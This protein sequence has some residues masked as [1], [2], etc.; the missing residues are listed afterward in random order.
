MTSLVK[1]FL[2]EI[3]L[4]DTYSVMDKGLLRGSGIFRKIII[5]F[6][7]SAFI[8][9][10][11]SLINNNFKTI[12]SLFSVSLNGQTFFAHTFDRM[13]ALF[14]L[15]LGILEKREMDLFKKTVK[16]GW[17]VLDIGANIGYPSLLFSK[18]VGENGKV[19]AFEPDKNNLEMLRKNIK[20]NNCKNIVVVPMAVSDRTGGG[21]LYISDSHSGDH[22]I[23]SS[24]EKRRT[25]NIKTTSLDDYFK[26][27]NKI[28]FIQMD[29]QGAEELVFKGMKGLL[30]ENKEI[31]ILLEF[32]PEGLR[33]I[34][35]SPVDFLKMIKQ[36][37][38]Q[39]A[40]INENDGMV[41]KTS[42]RE[43]MKMCKDNYDI[44]LFLRHASRPK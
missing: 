12:I 41:S 3:L 38:F 1:Y 30:N 31:S 14:L 9:Y 36:S 27:K 25:Q 4:V 33:K 43:C 20:V 7:G 13:I 29:V 37:G 21:T 40:Y 35:S 32:W 8:K 2:L 15:K 17:T 6:A 5:I 42:T 16:K 26:S 39:L 11:I 28:N 24:G 44:S 18:L 22:R 34:G 19:I 23:Y 10:I